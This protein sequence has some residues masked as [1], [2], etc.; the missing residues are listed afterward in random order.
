MDEDK[1]KKKKMKVDSDGQKRDK[2]KN[3]T[4]VSFS[5]R[6]IQNTFPKESEEETMVLAHIEEI[7]PVYDNDNDS[8]N[9][10][11]GKTATSSSVL[12]DDFVHSMQESKRNQMMMKE[13][14]EAETKKPRSSQT[15]V[16]SSFIDKGEFTGDDDD[17]VED[18][19]EEDNHGEK[20][21]VEMGSRRL[22]R[23]QQP[24]LK[25][26]TEEELYRYTSLIVSTRNSQD[27]KNESNTNKGGSGDDSNND[28]G[29]NDEEENND[30]VDDEE[31]EQEP[32]TKSEK[33]A[34]NAFGIFVG[35]RGSDGNGD[36]DEDQDGLGIRGNGFQSSI[37]Q[38]FGEAL[39]LV[40]FN[41]ADTFKFI[42]NGLC[43]LIIPGFILA[44]YLYYGKYALYCDSFIYYVHYAHYAHFVHSSRPVTR[45][46]VSLSLSL[47]T[48]TGSL[49]NLKKKTGFFGRTW[50]GTYPPCFKSDTNLLNSAATQL[51]SLTGTGT[52]DD[53]TGPNT[54]GL[55]VVE[56]NLTSLDT[57]SESDSPSMSPTTHPESAFETNYKCSGGTYSWWVR[58]IYKKATNYCC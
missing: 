26:T 22:K 55:V 57:S 43:Y 2:K 1:K 52:S 16:T 40:K 58:T 10:V 19:E 7:N 35:G 33:F 5:L 20:V 12:P 51:A 44:I 23:G 49:F 14:M 29:N 36:G 6:D 27:T 53:D 28:D 4:E 41:S 38:S 3:D 17:K 24:K 32:L 9:D 31:E 45:R 30:H 46:L 11:Y 18:E 50:G 39:H 13:K 34:I 54:I 42:K 21:D 37:R 48:H 47:I 15:D 25:S 56:G 8:D